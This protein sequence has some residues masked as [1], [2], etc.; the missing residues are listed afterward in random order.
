MAEAYYEGGCQSLQSRK[1]DWS[2]NPSCKQQGECL[3]QHLEICMGAT[4]KLLGTVGLVE[5]Q[6]GPGRSR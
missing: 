2:E 5:V 6:V 1:K 4:T 3:V